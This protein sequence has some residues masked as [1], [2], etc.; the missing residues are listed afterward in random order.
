MV[1]HDI[2]KDFVQKGVFHTVLL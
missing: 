1:I 2:I